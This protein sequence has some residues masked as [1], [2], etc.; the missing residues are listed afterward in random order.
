M[1]SIKDPYYPNG[2]HAVCSPNAS[3]TAADFN[4]KTRE[5]LRDG[6]RTSWLVS[7]AEPATFYSRNN[8]SK[9]VLKA[10][11][12]ICIDGAYI[13]FDTDVV[14]VEAATNNYYAYIDYDFENAVVKLHT[15]SSKPADKD[16]RLF[17][18]QLK[19]SGVVL[20][21][22]D[23]LRIPTY[24]SNKVITSESQLTDEAFKQTLRPGD[25]IVLI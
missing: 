6:A 15:S 3:I 4:E 24:C 25:L 10:P 17:L 12:S 8:N 5:I 23:R 19:A 22:A 11:F 14:S 1:A 13:S 16:Y 2:L 21:E 7:A 9:L 18:G 20:E